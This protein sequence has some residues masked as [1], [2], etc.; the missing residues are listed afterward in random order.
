MQQLAE[1]I[2]IVEGPSVPF[3]GL[4]YSTRMTIIRLDNRKLWIHSPIALN[5]KLLAKIALLG[6]VKY[7]VAP[8]HL[9]HLFIEPWQRQ[10][11]NARLYGTEQL[12][13]KRNDLDFDG[14]LTNNPSEVWPWQEQIKQVLFTG[15]PLMQECVF[16]HPISGVLVVTDLVENFN[17]SGFNWWQ[18]TLAKL[19]GIVAPNGKMPLDW[20]LSFMFGKATARQHLKL[21]LSW[22]ATTLVMSHGDIIQEDAT[23]FLRQSFGWLIKAE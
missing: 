2:W 22:Q 16:Y 4:P 5:D 8:N 13:I 6:E 23:N 15:S 9:H 19:T 18:R 10:F 21:I 17:P 20:R 12:I 3:L 1:N 14:A 7:L 11:P